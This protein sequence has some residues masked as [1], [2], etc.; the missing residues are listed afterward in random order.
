MEWILILIVLGIIIAIIVLPFWVMANVN[1]FLGIGVI[2]IYE[3]IIYKNI[4][5]PAISVIISF[6]IRLFLYLLLIAIALLGVLFVVVNFS[7]ISIEN[8]GEYPGFLNYISILFKVIRY[9]F[10]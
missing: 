6:V 2:C 5:V 3:F 8:S 9:Y 4:N 1:V 7:G 10:V